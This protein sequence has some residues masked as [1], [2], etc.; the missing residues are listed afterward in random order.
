MS[1]TIPESLVYCLLAKQ[2][3]TRS[4]SETLVKK[5]APFMAAG[6]MFLVWLTVCML[7]P[8]VNFSCSGRQTIARLYFSLSLC[9]SIHGVPAHMRSQPVSK[10]M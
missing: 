9:A 1:S 3:M 6:M 10:T 8:K 7:S 2:G 5:H 4:I